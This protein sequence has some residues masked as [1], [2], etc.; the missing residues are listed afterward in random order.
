MKLKDLYQK[1]DAKIIFL[2]ADGLGGIPHPNFKNLTELE[3]AKT[4][5]LDKLASESALGLTIPVD[6]GITPGSG[7]A[8]FSLFGYNP[9]AVDIGRGALE[10]YGIGHIMEDDEMAIRANFCT[11]NESKVITDRRAGRIETH[12]MERIVEKLSSNIRDIDGTRVIFRP[13][14]EHRFVIIL[15][16]KD[17]QDAIT[18]T[19]PQKEGLTLL[20][21]NPLRKEAEKT[22]KLVN[23]LVEAILNVLKD[24]PR[25]NGVLLRGYS[26]KPNVENFT[27]RTGMKALS[28]ANYPMYKGITRILGMD[29]PDPGESFNDLINYLKSHLNEYEFIYLHYKYAD[30]AGEDGD[31]M[32]K[33]K[34]IEEL[35]NYLPEILH[36]RPDVL[37][38]TGDHSTPSLLKSHS[39]HPNP[40]L[41]KSLYAPFDGIERFTER[42]CLRGSLGT[43]HAYH[44]LSIAMAS[45][46]KLKKW[47]A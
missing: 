27:D 3:Y 26:L 32:K 44:L 23:R 17:L 41:L 19:D 30:K 36:L 24:E 12:E 46:L 7:P 6:Y 8:H 42:N 33:V 45:A 9:S 43:L 16:G 2:V 28:L 21:P 13:G 5:N 11:I 4:P 25:A 37:V 47:G 29:T 38:I 22:A 1:N 20:P 10:A 39:W 18:D 34:A 40:T 35:D 31:F 14:K 15:K